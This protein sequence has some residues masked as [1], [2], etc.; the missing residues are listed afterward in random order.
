MKKLAIILAIVF[1]SMTLWAQEKRNLLT[2]A[3]PKSLVNDVLVKDNTW[4]PY[5]TYNDRQAWEKIPES[6]RKQYIEAG[7]QYL[8]YGWPTVRATEYLEF[9]RT[10]DRQIMERPQSA[11]MDALRTLVMAELMEGKGRFM[12]DIANGVFAFCEQTSWMLSACMYMHKHPSTNLPDIEDPVIDLWV[13]E[14]AAYLSWIWYFFHDEFDRISPVISRRLISELRDKVL[15]QFYERNDYWW[16]TGRADGFV[17]NWTPWCN[18]NVLTCIMLIEDDPVKRLEGVYKTMTSVDLFFNYYPNDGGCDEGPTYWGHAGGKAFGYLHLLHTA[19]KGRISI[20][21]HPLVKEIGRYMYRAHIAG[22]EYYINFADAS[23]R[24][25][26]PGGI[27]YRYG[28]KI[29]D[30]LLM[31]FG[32]FLLAKADYGNRPDIDALGPALEN[33]FGLEGWQKAPQSEPLIAEFYFPDLQVFVAR[34]KAETTAGFYIAAKGGHNDDSHNHNDV[35]SCIVFFNGDPVLV[36]AGVGTYTRE[37]FSEK[38]YEIWTMQSVYHN[39]PL[40][41]GLAQQPGKQFA[42]KNS[43]YTSSKS[44][45]TFSTD[46]A[47]AYPAAA[48]V[49]SWVRSYTLERGKK[50][51]IADKYLLKASN[52]DTKLHYMTP[53]QCVVLPQGIIEMKGGDFTLWL[54]YNPSQL[55]ARVEKKEIDDPRLQS[56]WGNHLNMLVFDVE[57][58]KT[59]DQVTIEIVKIK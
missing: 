41:N 29:E 49:D 57:S 36:D 7:E 48:L 4:V 10:G 31:S 22:G 32:A 16:I 1:I 53:L 35:G 50:I 6:L 58:K 47:S 55:T 13:G 28:Q 38:R 5:P 26:P 33:L 24:S 21:H 30:E 3:Y 17:N 51:A 40:I 39:L 44:K 8:D 54:K 52:G 2:N 14:M 23:P 45:V 46:I 19:S 20:F 42:A 15:T 27:I 43:K 37:T 11:R 18:Y 12:D 25:H 56:V 9:T 59:S 34:D